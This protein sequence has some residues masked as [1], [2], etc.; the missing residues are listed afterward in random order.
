MTLYVTHSY[1]ASSH[2][3]I[4][5]PN[6]N[7]YGRSSRGPTKTCTVVEYD[8]IDI[9]FFRYIYQSLEQGSQNDTATKI[10]GYHPKS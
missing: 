7:G 10:K 2:Q 8:F 9:E 3:W 6:K 1:K 4:F 5:A